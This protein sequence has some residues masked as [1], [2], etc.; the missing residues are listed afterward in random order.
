MMFLFKRITQSSPE[1]LTIQRLLFSY[2]EK[3]KTS[4]W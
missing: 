1:R 2:A 3:S 4:Y